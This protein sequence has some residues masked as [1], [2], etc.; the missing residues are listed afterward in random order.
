MWR[1][2]RTSELLNQYRADTFPCMRT[3]GS[4]AHAIPNCTTMRDGVL[5]IRTKSNRVV[6]L[7]WLGRGPGSF[8]GLYQVSRADGTFER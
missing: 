5:L 8:V 3:E 2:A 6:K 7:L 1:A 4:I